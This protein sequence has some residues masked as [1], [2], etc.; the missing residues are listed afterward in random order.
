MAI[1]AHLL[2]AT[3][4]S[5]RTL[6]S[7]E[8]NNFSIALTIGSRLT[9]WE[10]ESFCVS[11]GEAG[12][13]FVGDFRFVAEDLA[14][15]P[16]DRARVDRF[17]VGDFSVSCVSSSSSSASFGLEEGIVLMVSNKIL[18]QSFLKALRLASMRIL[19][20]TQSIYQ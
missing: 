3:R 7:S 4:P 19:L 15:F 20:S 10:V 2:I 8:D 5:M 12:D 13:F 16:P 6:K 11:S 9:V 18:T 17:G 14:I 1:L